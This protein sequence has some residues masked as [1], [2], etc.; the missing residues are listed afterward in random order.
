MYFVFT[1]KPMS[2]YVQ[3]VLYQRGGLKIV[4][5]RAELLSFSTDEIIYF[6]MKVTESVCVC[7]SSDTANT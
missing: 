1:C 7:A 3:D 5:T 4:Q 6:I 2:L